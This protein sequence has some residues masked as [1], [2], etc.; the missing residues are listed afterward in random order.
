MKVVAIVQARMG[1]VR[2]P[3]KMMALL[4]GR[5]IIE[6]VLTR[7]AKAKLLDE[8]VLATSI[9]LSDD[10]LC[11]FAEKMGVA[12][13]RGSEADVLGRIRDAACSANA[14]SVVR[15]CADNPF[16]DSTEVDRLIR[17]YIDAAPDYAFNHLN[18]MGNGYADGFGAE[19]LSMDLLEQLAENMKEFSQREHLTQAIW[20]CADDIEIRTIAAPQNLAYSE[21]RFDIDTP[22]DLKRLEHLAERVGIHG[23]AKE[24]V[25]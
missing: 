16:V 14:T 24:F 10:R 20:D 4:A 13:Y 1:S 18:K 25:E 6:W 5:P 23:E 19:I 9:E 21:M 12:V 7:V 15:I 17:F 2:F 22:T 8:V 3:G 11:E